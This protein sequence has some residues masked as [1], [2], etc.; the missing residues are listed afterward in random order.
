MLAFSATSLSFFESSAS[1]GLRRNKSEHPPTCPEPLRRHI[2][3]SSGRPTV[4]FCCCLTGPQAHSQVTARTCAISPRE[5]L[6]LMRCQ[7]KYS[8]RMFKLFQIS[9][10]ATMVRLS[11][12]QT[13][14]ERCHRTGQGRD[15]G[16]TRSEDFDPLVGELKG[17]EYLEVLFSGDRD[18]QSVLM[19]SRKLG[20]EGSPRC[21]KL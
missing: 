10:T 7:E 19:Q 13:S 20:F 17:R 21:C 1:Q 6:S 11:I 8:K 16:D 14:C 2:S 4:P 3:C 9:S 18:W 5:P 12:V 15:S